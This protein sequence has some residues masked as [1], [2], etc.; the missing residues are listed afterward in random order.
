[1]FKCFCVLGGLILILL[2]PACGSAPQT[3]S[4]PTTSARLELRVAPDQEVFRALDDGALIYISPNA[5]GAPDIRF[6]R[7][8]STPSGLPPIPDSAVVLSPFYEIDTGAELNHPVT[9]IL[10]YDPAPLEQRAIT[11]P[12]A[13][14]NGMFLAFPKRDSWRRV[15]GVVDVENH[16]FTALVS[17]L[18]DPLLMWD[19]FSKDLNVFPQIERIGVNVNGTWRD[20]KAYRYAEEP[21]GF[22]TN[23]TYMKIDKRIVMATVMS[24]ETEYLDCVALHANTSGSYET[25]TWEI[26]PFFSLHGGRN[27]PLVFTEEEPHWNLSWDLEPD[28]Y[29]AVG[30]LNFLPTYVDVSPEEV[31]ALRILVVLKGLTLDYGNCYMSDSIEEASFE[32]PLTYLGFVQK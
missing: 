24:Y 19:F 7:L 14:Q 10:P 9:L 4:L 16:T 11:N 26:H 21:L 5:L 6:E 25:T 20:A 2:L 22:H 12:E 31:E 29:A 17:E 13:I 28:S 3:Q 30:D 8:I 32:I 1:M 23:N 18:A 27:I 15:Y